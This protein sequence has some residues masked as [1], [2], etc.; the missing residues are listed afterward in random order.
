MRP[1]GIH[2]F[3]SSDQY[4]FNTYNAASRFNTVGI[5]FEKC[6]YVPDRI[7]DIMDESKTVKFIDELTFQSIKAESFCSLRSVIAP[8]LN[9][10]LRVSVPEKLCVVSPV[11]LVSLYLS[12]LP[13]SASIHLSTTHVPHMVGT[14]LFELTAS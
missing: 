1:G 14:S 2:W 9:S 3:C 4:Y 8:C 6:T 12:C 10:E 13:S 7:Q 11:P 5:S